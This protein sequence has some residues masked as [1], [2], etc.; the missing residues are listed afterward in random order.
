MV[1]LASAG[2][3]HVGQE[4]EQQG[5]ADGQENHDGGDLEDGEPEFELAEV[6]HAGQVDGR[7][8]HHEDQRE[9]PRPG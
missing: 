6:L 8:Y 7:E 5:G 4:P 3:G 9:R 1:M 2:R